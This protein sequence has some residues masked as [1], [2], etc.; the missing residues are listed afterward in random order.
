MVA[1]TAHGSVAA[2]NSQSSVC[3]ARGSPQ[4]PVYKY[5]EFTGRLY[6]LE[7]WILRVGV[8]PAWHAPIKGPSLSTDGLA[9][10]ARHLR[11]EHALK[12]QLSSG[13]YDACIVLLGANDLLEHFGAGESRDSTTLATRVEREQPAALA[14]ASKVPRRTS[15]LHRLKREIRRHNARWA[16]PVQVSGHVPV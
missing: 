12:P 8:T 4:S 5:K 1:R 7:N 9:V 15:R 11:A 6:V 16:G 10:P 3:G 13:S 14:T 2:A